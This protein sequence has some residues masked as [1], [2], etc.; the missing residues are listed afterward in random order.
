MKHY[1]ITAHKHTNSYT[2]I[3]EKKKYNTFYTVV[4]KIVKDLSILIYDTM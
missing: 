3:K 1:I 2:V 4:N